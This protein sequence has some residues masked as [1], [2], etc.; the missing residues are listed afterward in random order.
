MITVDIYVPYLNLSYDFSLDETASISS[1]INEIA[2]MVCL[3]EHWT[4]PETTD[5]LALFL[6]SEKRML[7]PSNSLNREGIKSG[8]RLILC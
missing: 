6:P 3:K 2:A 1:L 8:Q 5:E 7:N 4:A